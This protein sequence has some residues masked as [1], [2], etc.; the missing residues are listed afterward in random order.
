MNLMN[1]CPKQS[2]HLSLVMYATTPRILSRWLIFFPENTYP[3][4][5][6]EE[7][8]T[9]AVGTFRGPSKGILDF[10][11]INR[12]RCNIRIH[13]YVNLALEAPCV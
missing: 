7:H 9:Q 12:V 2:L 1:P 8:F 6:Q 3:V 10:F 11:M 4:P 13:G 5:Q